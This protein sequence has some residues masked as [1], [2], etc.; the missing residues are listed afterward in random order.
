MKRRNFILLTTA[1]IAGAAF[2]FIHRWDELAGWGSPFA[3]PQ[4]LALITS[5]RN[6]KL[7]GKTYVQ[8]F[9]GESNYNV[10]FN[11]LTDKQ[12]NSNMMYESDT[13]MIRSR[14]KTKITADFQN[15]RI[16]VLEG[17]VLSLTEARQ[18][19]LYYLLQS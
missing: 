9:P 6:I 15:D 14:L 17:W 12:S 16:M 11:L 13:K 3:Q 5:R 4:V 8:L 1:G 7:L 18:C 10:L 19:A 2:A